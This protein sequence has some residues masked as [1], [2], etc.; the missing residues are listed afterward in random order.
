MSK[1][2]QRSGIFAM[3]R[4]ATLDCHATVEKLAVRS[5]LLLLPINAFEGNLQPFFI[6]KNCSMESPF[7][8][9]ESEKPYQWNNFDS[10]G[11]V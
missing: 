1:G 6:V 11:R 3:P 10:A 2:N 8:P 7:F 4:L 9:L 5:P